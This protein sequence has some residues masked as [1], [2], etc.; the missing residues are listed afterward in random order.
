VGQAFDLLADMIANPRL[1][2][3]LRREQRV[4]IEE[5]KMVEDTPDEYLGNSSMRRIPNHPLGCQSRDGRQ[6]SSF[7]R[8]KTSAFH[9]QEYAPENL[10]IAARENVEHSFLLN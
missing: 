10:V 4:I 3:D 2:T 6:G 8:E 7:D 1:M 5:M 9:A